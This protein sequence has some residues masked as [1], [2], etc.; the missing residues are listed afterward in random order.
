MTSTTAPLYISS[1]WERFVPHFCKP[2]KTVGRVVGIPD[3][4]MRIPVG[5]ELLALPAHFMHSEGNF[6][7]WDPTKRHPVLG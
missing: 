3:A 5:G 2:G 4:G 1:I 7:F 6:Q